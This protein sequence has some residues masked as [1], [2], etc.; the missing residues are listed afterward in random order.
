VVLKLST[1]LLESVLEDSQYR[2]QINAKDLSQRTPIHWAVDRGDEATTKVLL[3]AGADADALDQYG[4]TP[5][6]LAASCGS[7]IILELLILHGAK[8]D[9]RDNHGSQAIHYACRHQPDVEPVKVLLRAGALSTARNNL[10]HT[11]FS[12]AAR[13]NRHAIGAHLLRAGTD[14]SARSIDGNTPLFE[15]IFHNSHEFL[16]LLLANGIRYNTIN[17]SGSNILHAAALEADVRTVQILAA[18]RLLGLDCEAKDGN[19]KTLREVFDTRF[20]APQGF[21][22]AFESLLDSLGSPLNDSGT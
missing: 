22:E 18:A 15:A 6:S 12:G 10:G 3:E 19:G 17:N 5:L 16:Q 21:G 2:K 1:N 14:T 4:R 11:P 20:N 7:T 8:V 9:A 13:K